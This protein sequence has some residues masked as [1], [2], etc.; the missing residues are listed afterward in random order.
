MSSGE[1]LALSG[2]ALL[3]RVL[4]SNSGRLKFV[5]EEAWRSADGAFPLSLSMP[6]T[7]P[8]HSHAKIDAFLWGLL[9]DNAAVL[10]SWGR[11]FQVSPRN[12]FSLLAHVG[13][14]CAGAVQFVPPERLDALL[15]KRAAPVDW[16]SEEQIAER[17]R[18][19]HADHSAWRLESDTGMFSLAGAQPK[20]A[21]LFENGRWGV[22]SG[23]TPTTHILKPPVGPLVGFIVN[24]HF[25]LELARRIEFPTASSRVMTFAGQKAIVVE[26]FDRTRRAAGWLRIHQE[27]LCQALGV[28][29]SRKY[30][31][32]GG[33]GPREIVELLRNYSNAP[34]D[35]V[36]TFADAL[37]FNWLIA[38]TD[39]HAKNYGI[40]IAPGRVRLAPLYDVASVLPYPRF[41]VNRIKLAMKVGDRY[42][43]SEIRRGD[44]LETADQLQLDPDPLLARIR[45][46]A[47][48][49]PDLSSEISAELKQAGLLEPILDRLVKRLGARARLC[50]KQIER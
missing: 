25:S 24:E 45:H 15:A 6:L 37:A 21:L 17:L 43:M 26:R 38:G 10:D 36:V 28:H 30:Q 48:A 7:S 19:L 12:A 3:G 2:K 42:R 40:L 49:I 16:L 1:L 4:R 35:D 13:E 8:E 50:L 47:E 34:N 11:Q 27:D 33:P 9:P 46:M 39:A 14:D 5:Y 18:I 29:P 32:D 44:W 20:T 22:P 41:D 31:N 23:R